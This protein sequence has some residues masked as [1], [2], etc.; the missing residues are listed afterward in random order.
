MKLEKGVD[1]QCISIS[2]LEYVQIEKGLD[3][4]EI[5]IPPEPPEPPRIKTDA[6]AL[7]GILYRKPFF[8]SVFGCFA[9]KVFIKTSYEYYHI[10]FNRYVY[11]TDGYIFLGLYD[12]NFPDDIIDTEFYNPDGDYCIPCVLCRFYLHGEF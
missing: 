4:E 5:I 12:P 3:Y 6:L 7:P 9:K 2:I 10:I 8:Y 11:T 1:Y